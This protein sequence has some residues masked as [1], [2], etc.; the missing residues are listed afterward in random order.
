VFALMGMAAAYGLER[1]A[2]LLFLQRREVER[3]RRR[4]DDLLHN[5]LPGSIVARLKGVDPT[6]DGALIA[7]GHPSVTVLF[8]DIVGFTDRAGRIA[9]DDVVSL[10]DRI[11]ARLDGLA[12]RLGLEKIKTIG[13]AYMAVA[14][15]PDERDDHAEAAAEMALQILDEGANERW[16]SGEPVGLRIGIASG[17]AVAG[18]IGRRKFAYDLWGDTVNLASRLEAGAEPGS[19]L[20]AESTARLLGGRYVLSGRREVDLK[21]MGPT[22]GYLLLGRADGPSGEATPR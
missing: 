20:V 16:P 19:I 5:T 21:G 6:A 7:D 2:R 3:E 18:V 17:P 10:L 8:A 9:P 14:G 15:A 1:S 11:F 12:D 13:D 22:P 4:A